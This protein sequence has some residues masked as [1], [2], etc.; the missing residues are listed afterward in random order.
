MRLERILV[1][2]G[3]GQ[4]QYIGAVSYTHLD[5]YKRQ[6]LDILEVAKL[7]LNA[8]LMRESSSAPLCFERSD[9]P[10]VDPEN[11][12]HFITIRME[13]GKPVKGIVEHDY[14]GNL[15]EEYEKRNQDYIGGAH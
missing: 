14:F 8:C 9:F 7:I 4:I 15:K 6:V 10:E 11:D 5:V 3:D 1:L 13:N 12:K 2:D